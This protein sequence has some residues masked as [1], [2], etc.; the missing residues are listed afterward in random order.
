[1][2]SEREREKLKNDK[3]LARC[4]EDGVDFKP[5]VFSSLGLFNEVGVVKITYIYMKP[6]KIYK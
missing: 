6:H 3:Y 4:R 5:F 2:T 1:M